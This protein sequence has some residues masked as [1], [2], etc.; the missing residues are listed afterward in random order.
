MRLFEMD[1]LASWLISE[2]YPCYGKALRQAEA[3]SPQPETR[4]PR[5]PEGPETTVAATIVRRVQATVALLV[6][7][8]RL[9]TSAKS[10]LSIPR[11]V[12]GGMCRGREWSI[13][14]NTNCPE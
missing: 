4:T 11:A 5:A 9:K 2:D 12:T 10:K 14:V 1:C 13:S 7:M 6:M 3:K 8:T